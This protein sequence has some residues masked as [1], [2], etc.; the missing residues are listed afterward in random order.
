[1]TVVVWNG[2][3]RAEL[4]GDARELHADIVMTPEGGLP[5]FTE[6]VIHTALLWALR[7]RGFF[8]LHAAAVVPPRG[9][10]PVV[11]VGGSQAGKTTLT[12]AFME[13]GFG[14]LGDDRVLL[15][16]ARDRTAPIVCSY[17]RAFHLG[18]ETLRAFP[19]LSALAGPPSGAGEKRPVDPL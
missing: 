15:R 10:A 16:R 1:S 13:A 6:G 8:D 2:T 14:Y 11:I 5:P 12:L 19:K 18:E 17:P 4:S 7:A 3:S 9:G